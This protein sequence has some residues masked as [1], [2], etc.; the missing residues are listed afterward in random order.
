MDCSLQ[1]SSVCGILHTRIM[2]WV[3]IPFSRGSSQ[4]RDWTHVF[5][6]SC[7]G[8]HIL[9]HWEAQ[10]QAYSL[11][12]G[13]P[14]GRHIL[15]HLGSPDQALGKNR[16]RYSYNVIR[17]LFSFSGLTWF[18]KSFLLET[19]KMNDSTLTFYQ[20]TIPAE[21]YYK[22]SFSMV[23]EHAPGFTFIGSLGYSVLICESIILTSGDKTC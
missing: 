5:C 23:L 12:L 19:K 11:P 2:E 6:I 21:R 15:Y 13:K 10:W 4:S 22:T 3:V 1:D 20:W 7:I 9:Y 18:S 14:T 8:R 17:S 16:T